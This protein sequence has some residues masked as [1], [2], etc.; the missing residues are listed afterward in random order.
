MVN[1]QLGKTPLTVSRIGFGAWAI[2][3]SWGTQSDSES[4]KALHVAA[5][6]GI[7]FFD[8]AASYGNGKSEELLG[9]FKQERDEQITIATKIPPAPG[10]WPP[11][12]YCE[13]NLRFTKEYLISKLE[14]RLR[15]LK[16]DCLDLLQIHTWTRA[17]NA[18]PETFEILQEIKTQGKI[19]SIGISTPEHD[20]N[21]VIDLIKSG[22]ID[23]VQLIYN[24]FDQEAAAELLPV[25][26]EYG[27]GVI[28]RVVFDEGSL[29]GKFDSN[30]QFEKDDFRNRYFAGDRLERTVKRVDAIK[31][32]AEKLKLSMPEL[33]VRFSLSHE[34]VHTVITGIRTEQQA[35]MN[36]LIGDKEPLPKEIIKELQ[37]HAWNRAFWYSGK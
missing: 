23:S 37:E 6:S 12:P 13:Q 33:A 20:Q 28:V 1:I 19:K 36:A 22:K 10:K 16:T 7:T 35:K 32:I 21:S 8:T 25:C 3:G 18:N 4:M 30:Y 34:A 24:I 17:W 29:T 11:S 31:P 5:D 2:G 27:I 14:E 26:K 15:L 9:R